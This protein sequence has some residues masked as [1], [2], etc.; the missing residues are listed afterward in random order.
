MGTGCHA[1]THTPPPPFHHAAAA[2]LPA[3]FLPGRRQEG[4]GRK[5]GTCACLCHSCTPCLFPFAFSCFF[6][7]DLS[8]LD[9]ICIILSLLF[10]SIL[11][12]HTHTTT[13]PKREG[14]HALL[15]FLLSSQAP[16]HRRQSWCGEAAGLP[17]TNCVSAWRR[18]QHQPQSWMVDTAAHAMPGNREENLT[19]TPGP[20]HPMQS[21]D[22][23]TGSGNGQ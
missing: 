4:G 2:T 21:D 18:G 3:T 5:G 6:G 10:S 14:V 22:N 16:H 7:T 8:L 1:H 19:W 20:H 17:H 12:T 23:G 13:T 9:F 15:L 11:H